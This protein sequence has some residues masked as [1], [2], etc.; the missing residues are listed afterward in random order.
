MQQTAEKTAVAQHP[1]A[2]A[3]RQGLVQW[4]G[5]KFGVDAGKVFPIL[6]ATCFKADKDGRAAS[7]AE[8]AA[9]MIVAREHGLNPFL[10]EI[11]AFPDKK[12]GI[13]PV[14]GVD[15]WIRIINSHPEFNGMAF[16]Y[17]KT[18]GTPA[19]IECHIYRKDRTHPIKVREFLSECKRDTQPW[20][21]HPSR[22]LRHKTLI[23][24]ARVA[25][26]FAGIFDDDEAERIIEGQVIEQTQTAAGKQAEPQRGATALKSALVGDGINLEEQPQGGK[27]PA[28]TKTDAKTEKGK[29]AGTNE[30]RDTFVK[31]FADCKDTEILDLIADEVREFEWTE[32]DQKVINDAYNKRRGE[33]DAR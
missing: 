29:V 28:E 13:V 10:K 8:V 3:E 12:G 7:D 17:E 5:Q 23:Q 24:C 31:K 16:E 27:A 15:G 14:V 32:P 30:Q 11:Y 22:M 2:A 6:K 9:L 19:W 1:A 25:F 33:L 18:E 4:A 26:G 20:K 21:S